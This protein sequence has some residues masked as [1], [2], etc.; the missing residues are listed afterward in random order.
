VDQSPVRFTSHRIRV[1][2][3]Q[4]ADIGGFFELI[5]GSRIAPEFTVVE[6]NRPHIFVS[7]VNRFHFPISLQVARDLRS[8][9]TQR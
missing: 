7:A 3:T 1:L 8:R 2:L 9:D 5:H 4:E 6:L